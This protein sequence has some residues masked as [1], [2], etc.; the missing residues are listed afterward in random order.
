[1]NKTTSQILLALAMLKLSLLAVAG[2][3]VTSVFSN[4]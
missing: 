3:I 2:S 1:M 4:L